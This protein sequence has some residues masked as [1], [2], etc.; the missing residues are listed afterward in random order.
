MVNVNVGD[1]YYLIESDHRTLLQLT[2]SKVTQDGDE[3]LIFFTSKNDG[4]F[5]NGAYSVSERNIGKFIFA[6]KEEA[7]RY[8]EDYRKSI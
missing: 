7:I 5:W 4:D 1:V 2:V 3:S 8:S 6:S